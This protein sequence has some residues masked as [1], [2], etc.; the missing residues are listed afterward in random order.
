M[1]DGGNIAVSPHSSDVIFC[2][3]NLYPNSVWNIAVSHTSNR[4]ANWEHDTLALGSNAFAIE[5]DPTDANRVYIGGDSAYN[6]SYPALLVSTDLGRTWTSSRT[7]LTGRVWTIKADKDN[8]GVLYCGTYRGVFK[9]TNSGDSWT[10][11]S[12]TR[13][14]RAL[15]IDPS[16]ARVIY[17]G[18]YGSGVWVSTD[19]GATWTELNAGL[20]C[21]RVLSLVARGNPSPMLLAGTEGG[22]VFRMLPLTGI[23][24]EPLGVSQPV[25]LWPNPCRT[26]VR[27]Q[28][29]P[30]LSGPVAVTLFDHTGRL[31]R[32]LRML[33][34]N[35]AVLDLRDVL[36]GTY[37]VRVTG[38][39]WTRVTRLTVLH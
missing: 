26:K 14:T 34:G 13:D 27:L 25:T 10:A 5:F 9:S 19:A 6:Y 28:L 8:P 29:P 17:A 35:L 7:G 22:A 11:T 37:F 39:N 21:N 1:N 36:T 31:V 23:K 32:E 15:A 3:G 12:F 18:T 4:G 38:Q 24:T 20:T 33:P 2:V 16:D 30:N